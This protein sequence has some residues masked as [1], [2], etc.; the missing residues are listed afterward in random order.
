MYPGSCAEGD[1]E[2]IGIHPDYNSCTFEEKKYG[3]EPDE[4]YK[5]APHQRR[6]MLRKSLRPFG[7]SKENLMGIPMIRRLLAIQKE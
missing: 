4:S 5:E 7:S 6:T 2:A 3:S 1:S